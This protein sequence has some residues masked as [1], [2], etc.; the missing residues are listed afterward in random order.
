MPA[1]RYR[2]FGDVCPSHDELYQLLYGAC[3][4]TLHPR[5]ALPLIYFSHS[6]RILDRPLVHQVIGGQPSVQ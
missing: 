6:N 5:E 1:I 4:K 2:L 3:I